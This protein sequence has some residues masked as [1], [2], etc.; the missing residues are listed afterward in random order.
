MTKRREFIRK[1]FLGSIGVTFGSFALKPWSFSSLIENSF[2]ATAIQILEPVVEAEEVV[3]QFLPADNG[4]GPMWCGGSSS[5]VRVGKEVFASGLETVPE[6]KPLNNCRWML[7]ERTKQGW[8]K[9]FTD[10]EGRTREPSPMATFHNGRFFLSANPTLTSPDKYDGPA[11][12]EIIQFK[13]SVEKLKYKKLLPVWSGN[14]PFSEHSYRS[15]AADGKLGEL[16]LFQNIGYTHAEWTFLDSKGKWSAQGKLE[17]PFGADYE[18][19]EPIRV[20]YPNVM[21]KER[22]VYFCGVSDIV[23]PKK[24]W[25]KFKREITGKE[26]DYD[27]RKL[28]FTW[29]DDITS[30]K[31][32]PWIEVASREETCGWIFP[33]DLWAAPDGSVHIL[34]TERALDE[35][36]REKFFPDAKQSHALNYAVIR[37]GEVRLRR[38]LAVAEEGGSELRPGPGRFHITPENRLFVI[39][40]IEGTHASG[41]S[42]S[43]NRLLEITEGGIPGTSVALPLK[44]PFSSF[45]TTTVRAGSEPSEVVDMLGVPEGS[46][47]TISYARIRLY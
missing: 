28:F 9:K 11:R 26:W 5:I 38:T 16:I 43:E 42:V 27:F 21:L 35:R 8:E 31:F 3:Y 4:A 45:F 10:K 12:P 17:W 14:P 20:C 23:E 29:S 7:F 39:Y 37:D 41:K 1:S 2:K 19:P 46:K 13:K 36:L 30:G 22:A 40:F 24:E 32:H 18:E 25:R 44:Q 47:N 15:L 34:W 6:W 33:S